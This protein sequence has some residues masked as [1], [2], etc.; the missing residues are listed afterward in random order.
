MDNQNSYTIMLAKIKAHRHTKDIIT[1]ALASYNVTGMEWLLMGAVDKQ[2]NNTATTTVLAQ[3]M[4]V[5]TPLISRFTKSLEEKEMIKI[6][7]SKEDKRWRDISLTPKGKKM[8]EETEPVVRD[9]LRVWLSPIKR[10]HVDIYINVLLQ[11]AYKL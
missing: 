11:V 2:V 4:Q 7:Q 6:V 5:S 3:E 10:E 1:S 9:A 8:L